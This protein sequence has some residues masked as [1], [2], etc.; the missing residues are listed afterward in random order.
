MSEMA[1]ALANRRER[2]VALATH[3][4]GPSLFRG[5][6]SPLERLFWTVVSVG[7]FAGIWEVLWYVGW[8][9]PRLLPGLFNADG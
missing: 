1:S 5:L 7:F 6:W 3:A 2:D 9:D 8:A 4:P